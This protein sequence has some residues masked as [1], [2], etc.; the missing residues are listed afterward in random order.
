MVIL[1]ATAIGTLMILT[2]IYACV[3]VGSQMDDQL[4]VLNQKKLEEQKE[5][6]GDKER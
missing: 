5:N 4:Q 6:D 2:V 3:V 1:I